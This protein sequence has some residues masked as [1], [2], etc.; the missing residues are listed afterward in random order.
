[1]TPSPLPPHWVVRVSRSKRK[2][3]YY[4][5]L[6]HMTQWIRP[7]PASIQSSP[8]RLKRDEPVDRTE[9]TLGEQHTKQEHVLDRT[10]QEH[11][12]DHTRLE[13]V[14]DHT[15]EEQQTED[16]Q[17][18]EEEQQ[19]ED[20]HQTLRE[21]VLD[22]IIRASMRVGGSLLS[23]I[24]SSK[25]NRSASLFTPWP[26][27]VTAVKSAVLAIETQKTERS[28]WEQ[29]TGRESWRFLVQ[30]STGAGKTLTIAALA[31]QL[32]SAK[33]AQ[34]VQ[35]HTVVVM[36][37]R[38]KLNEQVGDAVE[39]YLRQNGVFDVFRALSIDHLAAVL[40]SPTQQ[41]QK[42]QQHQQQKHEQQLRLQR[43]IITT[44][45]KMAL[46]V[47]DDVLVTR[48]LHRSLVRPVTTKE[49]HK[50]KYQ[51]VAIITDE[52]HRSHT[53]STRDAIEKVMSAG[54]GS[55]A[56]LTFVGFTATPNADALEL[57]GCRTDDGYLR[58]F[59]CYSIAQA[60]ADGRIMNVLEDYTCIR[61]ELETSVFSKSV[62]DLLRTHRGARRYIMDR[63]SDDIAVLKAKALLMMTDFEAV[64]REH[65]KVKC[66]IVVR[67]R[68]D[69]TR[70]HTLLTRFV[71][72]RN[73]GWICFAA[74]SG[75]VTMD[76]EDGTSKL[77]TEQTLNSRSVTLS[78]SDIIIVCD[79]LDTGYN[80]PLLACMYVDRY[81]RSSA[82][83]VQLLSR[84]NRRHKNKRKVRVLD[85]AN[86]AAQ[87]RRSFADFWREAKV[88]RSA[89]VIDKAA[90]R[91]DLATAIVV[92]CDHFQE[93]CSTPAKIED[94]C[95]FVS[96]RVLPLERDAFQQ[97]LDA[98]RG[99]VLALKR[100]EQ[101]GC[102][103][104]FDLVS[105]F[106]SSVLDE[107]K[108]EIE[109]HVVAVAEDVRLSLDEVK[110]KMQA[111]VQ[112]HDRSFS[113]SLYP[114][115]LLNRL[116]CGSKLTETTS[117]LRQF[118]E[119]ER[120]E[121][122]LLTTSARNNQSVDSFDVAEAIQANEELKIEYDDD[123]LL[124]SETVQSV[125]SAGA[126]ASV[127]VSSPAAPFGLPAA[128]ALGPTSPY[129]GAL[130]GYAGGY[131]GGSLSYGS[132]G[133]LGGG[134]YGGYGGM[135][136]MG[137]G[138][139]LGGSH[140]DPTNGGGRDGGLGWLSSFHQIVSSVGQISE[141]LGMNAEALNFC[142]GSSVHFL[143]RIG[144]M[145]AGVAALLAPRP[146]FPP[147]HPRHGEPP[148]TEEEE[149]S[150]RRRVRIFQFILS[151]A[152]L[153]V[154]YRGL[155]WLCART[156]LQKL[157]VAPPSSSVHRDLEHIFE[158]TMGV[159]HL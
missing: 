99:G 149:Q 102:A 146:V 60:I 85:F 3:Y 127:S 10:E 72:A 140:M 61:C 120:F 34:G 31:H 40:D 116:E 143:E 86:H 25:S 19:T 78:I 70:Y 33:D 66:M 49:E 45:Q 35:F 100:L 129:G 30:H 42:Q 29:V 144:A 92:L 150:R 156:S 48:L 103:S 97:V 7:A 137:Y 90:E 96:E 24:N 53:P 113:G 76:G 159:R 94:P 36:L 6:T 142:I 57:F 124:T 44:T 22:T 38:V 50:D 21:H 1:M 68:H 2:V 122:L 27:Q 83:T 26:H 133:L 95:T 89:D 75:T 18:T 37:D 73:L 111:R 121:A 148:V 119:L 82:H 39:R 130:G 15:N 64:E 126:A 98:L 153:A 62:H 123:E 110:T 155:R 9:P 147:V 87:V 112:K 115:S 145:C 41:L 28:N 138:G 58:P 118:G 20:E 4:H 59:H 67:S 12:R 11:V 77:V 152:T 101:A 128:S 151:M 157:L 134:G 135:S 84:L 154:L 16:E 81:L 105:P 139:S 107:L 47:K 8:K 104:Y 88:P 80:E 141:L 132:S 136:R 71:A 54:K 5:E 55:H 51:R 93:L 74:F 52:A 46:L 32:L 114:Q 13:H 23:Q 131:T 63:A 91:H 106:R 108:K 43:V 158:H 14:Q 69:V 117:C 125:P 109:R 56:R 65:P 17:P 79:K